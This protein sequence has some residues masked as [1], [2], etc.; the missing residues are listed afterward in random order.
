MFF[1]IAGKLV[2]E[3]HTQEAKE[4]LTVT[5]LVWIVC[6]LICS[7][8]VAV[9]AILHRVHQFSSSLLIIIYE[10]CSAYVVYHQFIQ[11]GG[12]AGWWRAECS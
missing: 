11:K 12:A 1:N 2:K 3:G 4:Q 10:G 6:G 7:V 8:I 9:S 5:G